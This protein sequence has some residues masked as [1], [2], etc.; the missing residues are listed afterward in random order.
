MRQKNTPNDPQ[1]RAKIVDATVALIYAGGYA[2][3][4]ARAV[5]EKA[6]VPVGSVSYHFSSVKALLVE[7]AHHIA[8]QRIA[9]LSQWVSLANGDD[10]R[11]VTDS[12]AELIHRQLTSERELTVASYELSLAGLHDAD[13]REIACS[14]EDA[15]EAAISRATEGI[16]GINPARIAS[17]A[18]G[19]QLRSLMRSEPPSVE[20][21]RTVLKGFMVK[22]DSIQ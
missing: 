22:S 19:L 21:L 18:E 4:T 10:A 11:A 8:E 13:L 20:E 7:A 12:L 14:I 5:A 17:L 16:P 15:L 6:G 2:S 3:V 1:R 9:S